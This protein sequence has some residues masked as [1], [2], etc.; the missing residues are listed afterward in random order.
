M[1]SKY[2]IR[3]TLQNLP[4]YSEKISNTKQNNKKFTNAKISSGLPFFPRNTKKLSNYQTSK[5]LQFFPK[6]PKK[7]KKKRQILKNILPFYDG[8][9]ILKRQRAFRGCAE[10]YNVE[11]VD[12]KSLSDSL[13]LAI[14]SIVDLFSDLLQEKRGLSIFYQQQLLWKDGIMQLTGMILKNSILLLKQ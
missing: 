9:G 4:F 12:R 8:V 14:S 3:N 5:E 13:F 11:T 7:L 2:K 1:T 10:T 6:R